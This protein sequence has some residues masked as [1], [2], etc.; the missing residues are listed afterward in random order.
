[1]IL[2]VIVWFQ[3]ETVINSKILLCFIMPLFYSFFMQFVVHE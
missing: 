1:M 2:T 3:S